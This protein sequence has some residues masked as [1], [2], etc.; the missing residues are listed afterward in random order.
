[1]EDS[2]SLQDISEISGI[3]KFYANLIAD[4]DYYNRYFEKYYSK[5][6]DEKLIV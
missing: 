4:M 1:M 3:S 2:H 5:Y 6:D